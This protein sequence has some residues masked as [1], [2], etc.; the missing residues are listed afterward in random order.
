MRH[1]RAYLILICAAAVLLL[2]S[3]GKRYTAKG[4]VKDY[5]KAYAVNPD[6]ID[7]TSFSDLDSTKVISDSLLQVMR[8]TAQKDALFKPDILFT[9]ERKDPTLLFIRMRFQLPDDTLEQSRTFYFDRD[10]TGIIAFK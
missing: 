5:V 4:L 3:C 1:F 9:A 10:L 7:I 6:K 2:A 8:E